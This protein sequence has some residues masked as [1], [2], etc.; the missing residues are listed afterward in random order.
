MCRRE[1]DK[2]ESE[3]KKNSSIIGD[4]KQVG[5]CILELGHVLWKPC[6]PGW[7]MSTPHPSASQLCHCTGCLLP[8][9]P[10]FASLVLNCKIREIITLPGNPCEDSMRSCL[11]ST[12]RSAHHIKRRL[13]S[14]GHTMFLGA[15][16]IQNHGLLFV[17]GHV[18]WNQFPPWLV[19]F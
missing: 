12:W 17:Y 13:I 7:N 16:Q 19:E 15:F 1:L 6:L 18:T 11:S 4:Y 5:P 14:E 8:F 9:T 10:H 3:I 2:A